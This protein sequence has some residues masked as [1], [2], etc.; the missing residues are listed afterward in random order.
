MTEKGRGMDPDELM[1]RVIDAVD[2]L[3]EKDGDLF[4]RDLNERTLT[5]RLAVY[6][7]PRF[8]GWHVD[9]EYN[10]NGDDPKEV[11]LPRHHLGRITEED[12]EARTVFPDVL[13]HQRN[14]NERNLLVIEAKKTTSPVDSEFDRRKLGKFREAPYRYQTTLFLVLHTKPAEK[15]GATLDFDLGDGRREQVVRPSSAAR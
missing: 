5:H 15:P 2:L 3:L 6:L 14:T 1:R 7:E 10:R 13:V 11:D 9:C 12:L 8:E 4:S